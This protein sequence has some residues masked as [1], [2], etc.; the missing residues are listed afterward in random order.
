MLDVIKYI[1]VE[2]KFNLNGEVE[3]RKCFIK[4]FLKILYSMTD[5]LHLCFSIFLLQLLL[6]PTPKFNDSFFNYC[7]MHMGA[8]LV[9]MLASIHTHIQPVQPI[10]F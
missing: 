5:S 2:I 7:F 8:V 9:D 10:Q 4:L 1:K 3:F 6:C